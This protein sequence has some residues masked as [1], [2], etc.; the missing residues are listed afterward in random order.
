VS[1]L[2]PNGLLRELV[3]IE[4]PTYSPG[5][6]RVAERLT[7]ELQALGASV[8]LHDGGHLVA[9]LAGAGEPL[10]LLG[11]GDTVWPEGTLASMPFKIDGDL[12]Y[13]PGVYDMKACLVILL[14]AIR[15]AG[16]HRRRLRVFVTADEEQ[17]SRTG[18]PLL[19]SAAAGVAAALVVEPATPS[20]DLK[21]AR[22]GLGRFRLTVSGRSAHAGNNRADGVSAIEE[23]AHQVL[24]IH[25]LNDPARGLSFNVGVVTG[26]TSENVVAASAEA[27]IDVRVSRN[28][29]L[30]W[31][32][33]LLAGLEPVLTGAMLDISGDWTRPPLE[34]SPGSARLFA[35]A[36]E[37]GLALGLDLHERS[38]GGGSDGNLVGALGI[39]VLDGLGVEGGGA[40]A[41]DEHVLLPSLQVRAKLLARLLV[42]PGI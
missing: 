14:E 6:L 12:V 9:E 36:R 27:Q 8:E 20:G 18:R 38:A 17:A 4:S 28:A 3:E 41:I 16:P 39:P 26:G 40:H 22:K 37:H 30:A 1:L 25:E 33:Q 29:D 42:D 23:L 13:G 19:E 35:K 11:H 7:A 15:L 2:Q 10:L 34:P 32:E 21:T 5:V 31:A 24:A